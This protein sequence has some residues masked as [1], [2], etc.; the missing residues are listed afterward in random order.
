MSIR[1]SIVDAFTD[2]PF[3]GNPAA[4]CLL[5]EPA[6]TSWMQA[7]AAEFNLPMTAFVTPRPAGG[8]GLRWFTPLVEVEL[9][10]HAT[11][12]TAHV[13]GG[14][15]R[16]H[17]R[18]G[19]L[20][21]ERRDDGVLELDFP[22]LA[23]EPA[24]DPSTVARATGIPGSVIGAWAGGT[25]WLA[26]VAG[27]DEVEGARP[28]EEVLRAFGGVL[29]VVATPSGRPGVDTVCRVF[30]PAAGLDEDAVTGSAHCVLAP[31]LASRTGRTDFVGEQLS[32]RGGIVRT[33]LRGD[34]VLLRGRAV[35]VAEGTVA[36]HPRRPR[37]G[38]PGS[39]ASR[40]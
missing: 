2:E 1:F 34:R 8:R 39:A 40:D 19:I 26:E 20:R 23:V 37:P 3:H 4:V 33:Q 16:F 31:W 13:L 11:L 28:D 27:P 24:Q 30:E 35:T 32:P 17:T 15:Q 21:C 10:G 25:W 12:A 7:V 9:C 38:S 6:P 29:I 36:V 22:A 5:P 14:I 18:S